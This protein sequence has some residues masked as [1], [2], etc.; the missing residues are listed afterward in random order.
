MNDT[1]IPKKENASHRQ[2][3][4]PW[5]GV[6]CSASPLEPAIAA[7][8][9]RAAAALA[10][11]VRR[12]GDGVSAALSGALCV[13]T[14]RPRL[15]QLVAY[16]GCCSFNA[17]RAVGVA[18]RIGAVNPCYDRSADAR[19]HWLCGATAKFCKPTRRWLVCLC[20]SM[21]FLPVRDAH[22]TPRTA[23]K[24]NLRFLGQRSLRSR[25][26]QRTGA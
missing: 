15:L 24:K 1:I 7:G 10:L 13:G 11:R 20:A 16:A 9:A 8:V 3:T 19:H 23:R 2:Y 21:R 5:S 12:G 14:R 25:D 22:T 18:R 6:N 26:A 4:R 17:P